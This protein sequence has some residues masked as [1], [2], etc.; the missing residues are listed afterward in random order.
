MDAE[1]GR[2]HHGRGVATAGAR[3]RGSAP[4][5]VHVAGQVGVAEDA[6]VEGEDVVVSGLDEEE[7]ARPGRWRGAKLDVAGW[8]SV[9]SAAVGSTASWTRSLTRRAAPALGELD[10]GASTGSGGEVL[11]DV[12]R[13]GARRAASVAL[14]TA[15]RG[16]G[17]G[18]TASW[19]RRGRGRGRVGRGR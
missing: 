17:R 16:R 4:R 12:A 18:R 9:Q 8:S 2:G 13:T 11:G 6:E 15:S 19:T 1:R 3:G 5:G 7:G 14:S 10:V